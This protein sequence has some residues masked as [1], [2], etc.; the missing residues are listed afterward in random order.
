MITETKERELTMEDCIS[1]GASCCKYIALEIDKPTCKRD[2]DYIRW[3]LVH[4]KTC[5]YVDHDGDWCLEIEARCENLGD[6][7]MCTIY[8]TRPKVCSDYGMGD[9][10]CEYM[11]N[12]KPY[13]LRFDTAIQF[14]TYLDKRGIDWK[15][16]K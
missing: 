2:Y 14:E 13:V 9:E 10:I 8:E 11:S 1:C 6:N 16:K 15:F 3:F 5:V 4:Q 12:T 7:N